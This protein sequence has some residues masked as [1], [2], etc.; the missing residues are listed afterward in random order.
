VKRTKNKKISKTHR[1]STQMKSGFVIFAE[2]LMENLKTFNEIKKCPN[3]NS[4]IEN[5]EKICPQCGTELNIKTIEEN[6]EYIRG[7]LQDVNYTMHEIISEHVRE[8]YKL[9]EV[10]KDLKLKL[11]YEIC[12]KCLGKGSRIIKTEHSWNI[13]AFDPQTYT[14]QNCEHCNGEG[15]IK[16][17]Y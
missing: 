9:K 7:Y 16:K 1:K 8:I 11:G 15:V 12:S 13:F 5:N 6:M 3:C 2:K 14:T 17:K 4:V 10:I